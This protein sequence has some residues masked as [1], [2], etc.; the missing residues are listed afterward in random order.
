MNEEIAGGK[1]MAYPN[2]GEHSLSHFLHLTGFSRESIT[3]IPETEELQHEE[4]QRE[5]ASLFGVVRQFT[6]PSMSKK[7]IFIE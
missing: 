2:T 6:T 7:R 4:R 5:L 1:L 3:S